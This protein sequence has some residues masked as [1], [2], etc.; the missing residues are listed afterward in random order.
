MKTKFKFIAVVVI[1]AVC[2]VSLFYYRAAVGF[3]NASAETAK[4]I[5]EI[6]TDLQEKNI[7]AHDSIEKALKKTKSDSIKSD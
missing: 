6:K 3:G 2:A 7:S 4:S 5:H 1:I